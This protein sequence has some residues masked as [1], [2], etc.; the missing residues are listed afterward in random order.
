MSGLIQHVQVDDVSLAPA[1]AELRVT[2]ILNH[3]WDNAEVRGRLMGPRCHY[4]RTVEIAYPL[5]PLAG[6]AHEARSRSFRVV[7]PEASL[8]DLQSPFLYE[9]PVE[10]W[11]GGQR[12]EK[13]WISHGLRSLKV[14]PAGVRLNGK[15][16]TL[17]GRE[18]ESASEADLAS[19]RSAGC[20]LLVAP[21]TPETEMLWSLAD[22][23]GF[24]VL[25]RLLDSDTATRQRVSRLLARASCLGWVPEL[26]DLARTACQ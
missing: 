12:L 20:N 25:G 15:L 23:L 21:V 9:G 26:E 1:Q 6:P 17:S 2:V 19:W 16:V 14:G 7:I 11:Q 13:A 10:L 8:W 4:S 5:R 24:L 22:R 18:V 3:D